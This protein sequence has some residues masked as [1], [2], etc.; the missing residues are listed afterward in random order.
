MDLSF[1]DVLPIFLIGGFFSFLKPL[2]KVALPIVAGVLGVEAVGAVAGAVTTAPTTKAEAAGISGLSP[3][4]Q[5]RVLAG[6]V[7]PAPSL[8]TT[9]AIAVE[10]RGRIRMRTI[11]ESFDP[12]TGVV[13]RSRTHAGGVAVFAADVA[14]ARRINRQVRKLDARLPRKIVKQSAVKMLTERVVKNALE[15]AGDIDCPP[16]C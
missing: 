2:I 5:A 8:T 4:A 15:K 12:V 9:Q 6:T 11:V 13:L 1:L 10:A 3:E 7:R 16:K 14:A